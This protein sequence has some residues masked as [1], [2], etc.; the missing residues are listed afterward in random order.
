M[1]RLLF[2]YFI[3]PIVALSLFQLVISPSSRA[4]VVGFAVALL[5]VFVGCTAWILRFIFTT[6]PRTY[7]FDDMPTVLLYGPLYNT[8]SDSAAPFALVPVLI[9]FMRGVAF[10]AVQPSGTGQV[11]I[12]AICEIILIITLNGFRP[13]QGQTSMNAYHTFFAVVRLIT[14]L[15]CVGFYTCARCQ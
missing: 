2:N 1:I 7:L 12:L 5:I 15:L 4:I 8:Y 13:F 10:G 11:V 9:T 3:L 14:V 6:K